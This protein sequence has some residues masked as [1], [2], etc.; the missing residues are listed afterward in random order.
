MKRLFIKIEVFGAVNLEVVE[1]T[2]DLNILDEETIHNNLGNDG[3]LV[4]KILEVSRKA[5]T[6]WQRK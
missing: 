5:W 6:N 3:D 1:A 2:K 4:W